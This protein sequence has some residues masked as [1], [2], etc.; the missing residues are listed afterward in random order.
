MTL[1]LPLQSTDLFLTFVS[2][3]KK[4]VTPYTSSMPCRV[5]KVLAPTGT[6]VKKNDPLLSIESMKTEV[7]LLSRHEG[8]VT[9]HVE[10]NQLVDA[11]VLLC[12]VDET[13]K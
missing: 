6:T 2:L 3:K 4:I 5:L 13:K 9:M 1:P 8:V 10:E 11:R 7:K 12:Q